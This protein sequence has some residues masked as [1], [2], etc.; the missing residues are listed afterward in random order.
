VFRLEA[1]YDR[2]M[3]DRRIGDAAAYALRERLRF[4]FHQAEEA[5]AEYTA[6]SPK[7][8]PKRDYSSL[9]ALCPYGIDVDRKLKIAHD[10][11]AGAGNAF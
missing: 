10:K 11:L 3:D 7:V 5:Q 2:Q 8:D 9:N 4:W 1:V 6:F